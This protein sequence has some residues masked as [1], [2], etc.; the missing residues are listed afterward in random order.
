MKSTVLALTL[1][2]FTFGIAAPAVAA[3]FSK[4]TDIVY[5]KKKCKKGETYNEK[6]KKCEKKKS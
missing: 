3:T 1:A 5:A 6:T 2:A 4:D